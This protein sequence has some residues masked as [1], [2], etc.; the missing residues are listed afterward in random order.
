M[1]LSSVFLPLIGLQY[2]FL[3]KK[4]KKYI[5][6]N[7]FDV[8]TYQHFIHSF[9]ALKINTDTLK[10]WSTYT[11]TWAQQVKVFNNGR[12]KK[13][14]ETPLL[15]SFIKIIFFMQIIYLLLYI[16]IICRR[17][18]RHED[19]WEFNLLYKILIFEHFTG[20]TENSYPS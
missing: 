12:R 3:Y 17:E 4:S 11:H 2:I 1:L 7:S 19:F 16:C 10:C 20:C 5:Y 13:E 8:S 18:Y 14:I 15:F 9:F 6:K